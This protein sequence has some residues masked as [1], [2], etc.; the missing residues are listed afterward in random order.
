M[1]LDQLLT[2]LRERGVQLWREGDQL[3]YRADA[4][5]L[6]P[7]LLGQLREQKP[8]ILEFLRKA[9]APGQQQPSLQV[10]PRGG[11][12]PLSFAQQRLWVLDQLEP[13]SAL[14]NIP[15]GLRL[16]GALN[17][18]VLQRCL[19]EILR[20]HE[21]LRT[22]FE[23]VEGQPVQAIQ[24]VA[25]LEMPLI[26][27]RGLPEPERE[28]EARR[29]CIQECQRPFD[30]ARDLLLRARLFRLGE[31]NHI[32]SLTMHHIASDGWSVGLLVSEL[33]SLYEA[34]VEGKPSPL[35]ELAV[36]VRGLC[37]VAEGVVARG[38]AGETAWLLEKTTGGS[39]GAAGSAD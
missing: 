19:S 35:P 23:A 9:N 7:E 13:H 36:Q 4:E 37:G 20:R 38:G 2:F 14:Y 17:V 27:L 1:M 39:T 3:R 25:N 29:L 32:L 22:R 31:T 15:M 30:L 5:T 18:P 24:P 8:A 21:P 6:T 28:V 33:R 12:R 10:A 16:G 26:D 11:N 34:F